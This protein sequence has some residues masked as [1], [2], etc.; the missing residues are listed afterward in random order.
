MGKPYPVVLLKQ[1][2]YSSLTL[3][4]SCP[5]KYMLRKSLPN[6]FAEN[7]QAVVEMDTLDELLG[8]APAVHQKTERERM[9][10]VTFAYGKAVGIGVQLFLQGKSQD[11]IM[12]G[13]FLEWDT[14]LGDVDDK[15][16][17]SIEAAIYAVEKF[18]TLNT[19]DLDIKDY[20]LV[21]L[22][23]GRPA[24]EMS[25]V[26]HLPGGARYR[27]YI[28]AV[29]RNKYTGEILVLENKTTGSYSVS[30]A[31]YKNSEQALGYALVLDKVFPGL[32]GYSVLYTVYLTR[33]MKWEVFRFP[34]TP[35][36][37]AS[38]LLNTMSD[39]EELEA[40][41]AKDYFPT[42]GESCEAFNSPCDF[43]DIC[44]ADLSEFYVPNV[45]SDSD[46]AFDYVITLEEL[47]HGQ[48]IHAG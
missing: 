2:S 45:A 23:S 7:Q 4:H 44:H 24:V 37:R 41:I 38:W 26:I 46:E 19:I 13:M 16:N 8:A 33:S 22:P 1:L 14:W 3:L 43:L 9:R 47:I 31:R 36:Q 40:Y 15:S 29:I 35:V 6:A 5:R 34:K 27:G 42:R 18:S 17:K 48:E 20:E 39:L 21:I 12:F 30:A 28:D 32:S 11:E 25:F 10:D